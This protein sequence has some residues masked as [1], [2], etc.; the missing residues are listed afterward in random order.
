MRTTRNLTLVAECFMLRKCGWPDSFAST[1]WAKTCSAKWP[2]SA[3]LYFSA[4]MSWIDSRSEWVA[5]DYPIT[6]S[7]LML[8]FRG[9]NRRR[10]MTFFVWCWHII[11][12][13]CYMFAEIRCVQITMPQPW[14][15]LSAVHAC[16]NNIIN[17]R[18]QQ[19]SYHLCING[20]EGVIR[21]WSVASVLPC[22]I[23]KFP[24]FQGTVLT[25]S[26][27]LVPARLLPLTDSHHSVYSPQQSNKSM[28]ELCINVFHYNS[29]IGTY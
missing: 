13:D 8:S 1:K 25:R 10:C 4:V 15:Q 21:V 20:R 19:L 22:C 28:D 9:I 27:L 26:R 3:S 11:N 12:N 6:H 18:K 29:F 24:S 2:N 7:M 16:S 23:F 17:E 14:N 5:L